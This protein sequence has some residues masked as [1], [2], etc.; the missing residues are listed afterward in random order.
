[1]GRHDETDRS[2]RRIERDS[3]VICLV[4]ILG[5]IA[6]ERGRFGMAAGVI[7]GVAMMMIVYAVVRSA[8][9]ASLGRAALPA[10]GDPADRSSRWR[11]IVRA[12]VWVAGRYAIFA[13]IALV[14]L[15]PLRANPLGV[16]VGVSVPVVAMAIEAVRLVRRPR[17]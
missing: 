15:V 16:F 11:A 7:A 4:V 5:A 13:V 3:A 17:E 9:D 1:M 2:L 8:V 14:A 10:G 12:T 6:V